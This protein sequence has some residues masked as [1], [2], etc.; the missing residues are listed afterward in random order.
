MGGCTCGYA[1]LLIGWPVA[2]QPGLLDAVL[3]WVLWLALLWGSL[4]LFPNHSPPPLHTSYDCTSWPICDGVGLCDWFWP[5]NCDI[6]HF[7]GGPVHFRSRALLCVGATAV[8]FERFLPPPVQSSSPLPQQEGVK[9]LDLD[10]EDGRA[11]SPGSTQAAEPVEIHLGW[12][13][14]L[15]LGD[16]GAWRESAAE[17]DQSLAFSHTAR[18]LTAAMWLRVTLVQQRASPLPC[19]G[20]RGLVDPMWESGP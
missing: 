10:F 2:L 15:R 3:S 11:F 14:R 1:A 16:T 13:L 18:A 8:P 7:W 12:F 9:A 20:Q 4:G 17:P 19:L 5:M 6:C